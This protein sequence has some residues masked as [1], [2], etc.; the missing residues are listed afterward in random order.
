MWQEEILWKAARKATLLSASCL[1]L[2]AY[3]APFSH[4]PERAPTHLFLA[5]DR[6]L[7]FLTVC[8]PVAAINISTTK[9]YPLVLFNDLTRKKITI[10]IRS[11]RTRVIKNIKRTI[12]FTDFNMSAL[13]TDFEDAALGAWLSALWLRY[14]G[15]ESAPGGRPQRA[16]DQLHQRLLSGTGNRGSNR[17]V[18]TCE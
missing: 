1:P 15:G 17:C 11:K 8:A 16:S 18:G 9:T 4:P 3:C 6:S 13:A 7:V 2:E 5:V 10:F 14:H 12:F